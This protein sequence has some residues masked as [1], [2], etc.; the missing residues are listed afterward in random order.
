LHLLLAAAAAAT[1]PH[2]QLD[3]LLPMQHLALLQLLL[4]VH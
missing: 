3:S 2:H 4:Q 1:L